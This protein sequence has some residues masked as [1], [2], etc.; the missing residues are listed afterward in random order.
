MTGEVSDPRRCHRVS[1]HAARAGRDARHGIRGLNSFQSTRPVRAATGHRCPRLSDVARCFNPRGPCG[2][3]PDS[4]RM[5]HDG[6]SRCFN[7]RG[8]CGPRLSVCDRGIH[9]WRLQ[10]QSTRLV[11]AATG[12]AIVVRMRYSMFQ[13]T[14]LV[15]AA[16][17][18]SQ[19]SAADYAAFQSTRPV[20]AATLAHVAR[21]D[22]RTGFNPRGSCGPRRL[23]YAGRS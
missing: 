7:P 11:R 4:V 23:Q 14:R 20:R 12:C 13:S 5:T 16:T 1:I 22:D 18:S 8:P 10:F 15:R 3:R 21:R 9:T 2:P 6:P 17:R 19:M